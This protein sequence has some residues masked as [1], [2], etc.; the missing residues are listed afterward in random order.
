MT[1]KYRNP[2]VRKEPAPGRSIQPRDLDVLEAVHR[3]RILSQKQIQLLF[4]GSRETAKYRLQFLFDKGYL[5]RKFLPP[6]QG[7]GRTPILYILDRRGAEALRAERGYE[8]IRFY[9]SSKDVGEYFLKH[10]LAINDF[11][12]ALTLACRIHGFTFESWQT[13]NE[14]KADYDRVSIKSETG[15]REDM[16][17]LPDAIFS[18]IAFN[19][20]N[21]CMLEL[22][23]G[24]EKTETFTKKVRAY[25]AYYDSGGY[26]ARYS[27]NSGR[28]LTIITTQFQGE[29]RLANLKKATEN[30]GGKRRFWFALAK[31]I[32]PET[33]LFEPIWSM[34]SEPELRSLVEIPTE[35]STD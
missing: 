22:D 15:K 33:L 19:K 12:V 16:P 17:I 30:A 34:A 2:R 1:K 18:F 10:T 28:V 5:E 27:T 29:K 23:R 26:Q 21:R 24:M 31:N 14:V 11:M 3:F 25:T 20:R 6:T 32:T 8:D 13:E 4:F 9:S 7:M 35:N